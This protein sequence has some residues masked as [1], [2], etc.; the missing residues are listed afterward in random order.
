[1]KKIIF[2]VFLLLSAITAYGQGNW[3]KTIAESRDDVVFVAS[4]IPYA[5]QLFSIDTSEINTTLQDAPMRYSSNL[6][7]SNT[8]LEFPNKAGKMQGFKIQEAPIMEAA[9]AAQFPMIKTYL[10]QGIEDPT[11]T[12]RMSIGTDGL[13]VMI[14]AA[15]KAPLYID[16][17][18]RNRNKYIVYSTD[19]LPDLSEF[20][21]EFE[22]EAPIRTDSEMNTVDRNITDGK[23]RQYNLAVATTIEYSAF[24]LN[25]QNISAGASTS[26]KKAAVLSAITNTINRVTGIYETELG[27]TFVLNANETDIIFIDSDN[28]SNN[29]AYALIDESQVEID[30]AIGNGNY[31]VG[32]TFSTG[33]G[34]LASLGSICTN[35]R[36]AKGITGSSSPIGDYYDVDYVAH[37]MG[38]QFGA[39]HSYNGDGEGSCTTSNPATAAEPG[40]GTTIMDYAGI[41]GS[42]NVQNH[43]DAYFHIVS[44]KEINTRFTNT[45]NYTHSSYLQCSTDTNTG[46]QEP[47]ANAGN[48]YTIPKGTAFV[49]YGAANDPDGDAMTYC[50]SQIDLQ[51]PNIYPLVSTT[52][53]G[54]LYR[55]YIPTASPNRF[56]PKFETVFGGS[57]SSTWEVTPTVGRALNFSL[58]ARD[59]RA[60]GGQSTSDDMLVTVSNVAGPFEV[61]SQSTEESWTSGETKA[62][63]W[64]V[65]GTTANGV[66]VANVEISL[67]DNT[68]A[69]L[70]VLKA[71]TPNDGNESITVPATVNNNTRIRVKAINNIFYAINSAVIALNTTPAYCSN[72]CASSG[73]TQ[74]SDGTTLVSF[75]TINNASSGA[76]A[77]S[78]YTSTST[79]VVRGQSYSLTVN[80]NTGGPYTEDAK[81]WI[82]W[83]RDCDF[84]DTGEEYDL[85]NA[86]DVGNGATSNSPLSITIPMTAALGETRMR[87]TSAYD[88]GSFPTSCESNFYGEV[89][90]YALNVLATPLSVALIDFQA[91]VVENNSIHLDWKT[92]SEVNN[93]GFELERSVDG[94]NFEA[95]SW[96]DG[97]GTSF[98]QNDYRFIDNNVK[99]NRVYYY[100][101]KQ[102]DLEGTFE[103]SKIQSAIIR[104]NREQIQVFPNPASDRINIK[105]DNEVSIDNHTDFELFDAFGKKVIQQSILNN[106][107]S[108]R[109]DH[110]PSGIYFYKIKGDKQVLKSDKLLIN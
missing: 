49:L 24:H 43:S 60:D 5:Y 62:I 14:R 30:N 92:A 98:K 83:N 32:H 90:D 31:D 104:S 13:H 65:A 41:C 45:G 79:N 89:E 33:G 57:L 101:L 3:D 10:G 106:T 73:S 29:N 50:W 78:D 52:T 74:D 28:F 21:C 71:S 56:M 103:Y 100:R 75:G 34:G 12:L 15:D 42:L 51:Q 36:K 9:L 8:I 44:I 91:K 70:N 108:I 46:N 20:G 38:H 61:T 96:I 110:L 7:N 53:T 48:D 58:T 40:S 19:D 23:M 11:A 54:P 16:P 2:E 86:M 99:I 72:L 109:V 105:L 59:N 1:M 82:D 76:P 84:A 87:V 97:A 22:N 102:M 67:I 85:G 88:D 17:Y 94:K 26:E 93:A 25:N 81:V 95:I 37:E 47:V 77:Y 55:S 69:I 68:G 4:H 35:A 39:N 107:T 64:N 6:K 27:V 18:T 80:V 63:T 66:N